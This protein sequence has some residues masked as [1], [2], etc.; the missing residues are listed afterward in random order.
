MFHHTIAFDRP[1]YLVLLALLPTMWALGRHA[2]VGLGPWRRGLSLTLRSLVVVGIVFALADVQLRREHDELTVAY[3]LDQSLSVPAATRQAMLDYVAASID[4]SQARR[5]DDRYAV[6]AFGRD[7]AVEAPPVDATLAVPPR[8]ESGVDP[9]FSNLAGAIERAQSLFP[10]NSARRIVLVTDGNENRGNVYREARAAA[11]AGVSIDVVPVRLAPRGDV[12]VEKVDVPPSVRRGQPFDLR[13]VLTN[14]GA[15]ESPT[16]GTLQL[17]RKAGEREEVVAAEPIDV[18]AGRQAHTVRQQIDE[19]DFYVYEARFVPDDAAVDAILQ[20]NAATAFTHIRGRG[21]VLM[22]ENF[23]TRG[24]FDHFAN[25]LRNE[26]LEVTVTATDRLFNSLAELQRYDA[27]VLANVSRGAAED[28]EVG[29]TFSDAQIEML[30]RNTRE[31]GC[32]LIMLGGPDTFGA[33]GWVNTK[34]EEAMP[35]DFQIRSAEVKMVGALA[36]V[37]D[38]SGSMDGEKLAMSKAAA[39]AAIGS[40]GR[41]DYISV[42]A[43]DAVPQSIVPLRRVNDY[44]S[45]ARRVDMLGSAGGTDVFPAMERG[46]ADLRKAD[47]A[48]KHMIVLTDGQTPDADFDQ[49]V[50]KMRRDDISVTAIA[51]GG[52][53]NIP[54]LQRIAT[55]GGGKFYAVRNPRN[56][57]RIFL[58]EVRRVARPLV[59]EPPAPVSLYAV[60]GHEILTGLEGGVPPISGFVLTGV[61]ENPLVEVALR[62]PLPPTEQNATVLATWT[63]GAGKAVAWT[64]DAGARWAKDWPAWDGYNKFFSQLVRWAMRPVGDGGN[65][66]VA[67]SVRD[68][69]T[70]LVVTAINADDQF[71]NDQSLSAVALTPDLQPIDVRLEQTAPGRYVGDFS[72]EAAGSYLIA[73]NPGDGGG[74]IRTGV[75]VGYSPEYR[76]QETNLPLLESLARLNAAGGTAG[77]LIDADLSANAA[78]D[79]GAATDPFRRDLPLAYSG[80]SAWPW[81]VVAATCVFWADV[82]VRRVHFDVAAIAATVSQYLG[83]LFGRR[84]APAPAETLRRLQTRKAEIADQIANRRFANAGE[85]L[86]SIGSPLPIESHPEPSRPAATEAEETTPPQSPPHASEAAGGSIYTERLLKAKKQVRRSPDSSSRP[87]S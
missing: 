37:I 61:K 26:G 19:S 62:S 14:D 74:V 84:Q 75:S 64:T 87:G 32:G 67:T 85:S 47:A 16:R 80:Q 82:F 36:I 39:I 9:E 41:R 20:N 44:R 34:L 12:A 81:F 49:L 73:I 51:V 43:F 57:P 76:D 1:G 18:P 83:T 6:V 66:T 56:L 70:Q 53:A 78:S 7:A 60:G 27:V 31:L 71:L 63:Y 68:G 77:R 17:I 79:A 48:V 15:A 86:E 52:D 58:S 33:G 3:V 10:P 54:L 35:V 4:G 42:T 24:Q 45:A 65:F 2:L 55:R 22:I 11:D 38:R 25:A 13:I 50:A 28:G 46:Y 30:V 69:R 40:L 5:P 29:A 72:S 21:A 8:L 59:Y 23:D